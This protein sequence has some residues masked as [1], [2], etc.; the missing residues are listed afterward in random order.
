MDLFA[1]SHTSHCQYHYTLE[2]PLHQETLGLNAFNCLWD[3][4]VSYISLLSFNSV[5]SVQVSLQICERPIHT[6]IS[7]SAL[8]DG[9]FMGSKYFRHVG[10]CSLLVC[11]GEGIWQDFFQLNVM[12]TVVFFHSVLGSGRAT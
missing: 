9:G 3:F 2:T 10:G 8:L 11:H 1:S 4:H 5:S 12:L 7:S 6:F